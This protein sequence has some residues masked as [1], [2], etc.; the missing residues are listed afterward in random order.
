M[1]F[2]SITASVIES[3]IDNLKR[4]NGS[5]KPLSTK[6][7]KNIVGPMAKIWNAACNDHNWTLRNPFSGVPEKYKE[8]K[9]KA[10]QKTEREAV[11]LNDDSDDAASTRDVF[12]VTEWRSLLK[13]VDSHYHLVMELLLMGMIGSELEALMKRDI[14]DDALLIRCAVVR[15]K[16]GKTGFG[17]LRLISVVQLLD[18]ISN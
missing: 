9:D 8:I 10:L 16:A 17:N 14:K 11:V 6:R 15:D 3:F 4:S 2:A 5:E 1:T 12:L 18:N 7:V 13:V